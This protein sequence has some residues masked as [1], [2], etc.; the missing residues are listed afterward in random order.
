MTILII[1]YASKRASRMK[2]HSS[3]LLMSLVSR[4]RALNQRASLTVACGLWMSNCSTYPLTR[5]KVA[6]SCVQC[7][8]EGS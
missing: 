4:K 8:H 1:D 2:A 7:S 5:A 6:K 3:R